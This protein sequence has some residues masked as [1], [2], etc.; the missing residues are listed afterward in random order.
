MRTLGPFQ[1]QGLDHQFPQADSMLDGHY[2]GLLVEVDRD[3]DSSLHKC[4]TAML[5]IKESVVGR[6]EIVSLSHP[7]YLEAIADVARR[8]LSSG[9]VYDALHGSAAEQASCSRI[10]TNNLEHF[11]SICPSQIIVSAPCIG[12]LGNQTKRRDMQLL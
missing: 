6:L 8:D 4:R 11:R 7:H 1:R 10:Y 2:S 5:M 12:S 3:I 9:I